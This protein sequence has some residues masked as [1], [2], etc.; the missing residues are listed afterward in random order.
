MP[1]N[2]KVT[3]T[4]GNS[5]AKAPT[6]F[7]MMLR[8][9]ANDAS[10]D[11]SSFTGDDLNAILTAESIEDIWDADDRPPLNF[12]HIAGCNVSVIGFEVKFSR[13]GKDEI[14]T[15]FVYDM[16][17]GNG[18]RKMYLMVRM[19]MISH[20]AKKSIVKLPEVGEVFQA[21]TSARYVVAKLWR[22]LTIGEIDEA[23]GKTLEAFIEETDLGG[24]EAVIKLR[25]M[26]R[27][28]VQA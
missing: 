4:A 9:M 28:P 6:A 23:R 18:P 19:A 22:F 3:P 25:E 21:N 14:R 5:A 12:Q 24:G 17:D 10:A 27:Q 7:Q 8:A 2:G 11:D 16:G 15:P 20:P 26:A 13:G 1:A